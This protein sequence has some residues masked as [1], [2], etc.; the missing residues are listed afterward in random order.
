MAGDIECLAD[1]LHASVHHVGRGHEIGAGLGGEE[2]HL[3]ERFNGTVIVHVGAGGVQDAVVSM[4]GVRVEG[5]IGENHRAGRLGLHFADGPEG[6]VRGVEC[7]GAFGG[8]AARV[9]FREERYAMDTEQ[10][11]LS[12]LGR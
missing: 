2:R 7:F 3:H 9:D 8:L 5:D 11:E 10:L 1:R 4:R 12:T 6:E